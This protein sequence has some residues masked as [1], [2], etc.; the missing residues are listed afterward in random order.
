MGDTCKDVLNL[1]TRAIVIVILTSFRQALWHTTNFADEFNTLRTTI[2]FEI[3]KYHN[4]GAIQKQ[5]NT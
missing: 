1:T 5:I 3:N 4:T 2:K